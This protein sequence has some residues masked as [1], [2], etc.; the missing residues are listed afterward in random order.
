MAILTPTFT[1]FSPPSAAVGGTFTIN[2]NNLHRVQNVLFNGD[3]I[4]SGNP[5][6]AP[7]YS[8]VCWDDGG[9]QGPSPGHITA[10]SQ[11]AITL[12]VPQFATDGPLIL[13]GPD[14]KLTTPISF[15]VT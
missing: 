7:P 1:S 8:S 14:R 12:Q 9:A 6:G 4:F 2:G 15:N 11:T 5:T 3:V 13:I 10:R